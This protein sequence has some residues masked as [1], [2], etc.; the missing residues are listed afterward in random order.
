MTTEATA[1][2]ELFAALWPGCA[3]TP[4]ADLPELARRCGVARVIVK[5]ESA[6]P[7]GS[8][9]SLGGVWA[10][11]RALARATGAPGVA[12][13]LESGRPSRSL[14]TLVCASD[15]NHGLAVAAAAQLAG[16]S[17]R[18]YLHETVS[19]LRARRISAR[20]AELIFVSGTFDDASIAAARAAAS[21]AGLLIADTSDDQADTV[22]SDVMAGYDVIA[23]ELAGQFT[24]A[25]PTHLFVQAG[26]GGLAAALAR[27]LSERLA[28]P[29]S[30]VV[31]EPNAASCV[32][33]AMAAGRSK[34]TPGDLV[35]EAEMLSCGRASAPALSLLLRHNARAIGVD[36]ATLLEAVRALELAGG[37]ATTASGAAGLAGLLSARPGSTRGLDLGV[38]KD[39][40]ILLIV[41]EGPVS[42]PIERKDSPC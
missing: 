21:G 11:L 1:P 6:R 38:D 27:G 35:T 30:V 29:P 31:V 15:G 5:N 39:S 13:L 19:E 40:L 16:A 41:T 26:V 3:P 17:A 32:G 23:Q 2:S 9:K 33:V 25:T 34:L 12:A 37:P 4:L 10:G 14:P 8:F 22:V 20:G 7:L 24:A 28:K 18:I 36:E 42:D